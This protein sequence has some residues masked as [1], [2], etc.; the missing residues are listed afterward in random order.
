M[1]RQVLEEFLKQIEAL[2]G[3]TPPE[4]HGNHISRELE[5]Q[6][7]LF[8]MSDREFL[9]RTRTDSRARQALLNAGTIN[10]TYF[11]REEKQFLLLKDEILPR[12]FEETKKLTIWSVSCSTG[13]EAVSLAAL[14][15]KEK[16]KKAGRDFT[17]F[18]SDIN[19]DVL[20]R[21]QTGNFS[22][23]SLRRDGSLFHELLEEF[24]VTNKKGSGGIGLK[25]EFLKSITS[26]QV[27]LFKDSFDFLPCPADLVFFRN[28][29]L[30]VSLEKRG[31]LLE[32]LVQKLRP[33]GYFFLGAGEVPFAAVPGLELLEKE[34]VYY[35]RKKEILP[36]GNT[37]GSP[38]KKKGETRNRNGNERSYE[39]GKPV[40]EKTRAKEQHLLAILSASDGD[41]PAGVS[42]ELLA[43]RQEVREFLGSVNRADFNRAREILE[44][45]KTDWGSTALAAFLEGWFNQLKG[46]KQTALESFVLSLS[47]RE[48]FWPARFY[49]ALGI[50]EENP[51]E[52]RR[53]MQACL[54]LLENENDPNRN[55]YSFLLED[56]D[57]AYFIYMCRKGIEKIEKSDNPHRVKA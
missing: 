18:A 27:N 44:V 15:W 38:D 50:R 43:A 1:T 5:K 4:S 9:A 34:G 42:Q 8:N 13:E 21:L 51:R 12:L 14:A 41:F 29:L 31:E 23:H 37:G 39:T 40:F 7:R 30:Y 28:T 48:D 25:E 36:G 24:S 55:L 26:R 32:K 2:T 57:P 54:A 35:F 16:E 53:E 10:E 45:L 19:T 49:Y 56:F 17:I 22:G 46:E 52:A 11:F 6:F 33:G 47:R 3:M 20:A